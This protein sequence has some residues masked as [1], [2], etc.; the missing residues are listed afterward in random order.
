MNNK[1][2]HES[3]L[4]VEDDMINAIALISMLEGEVTKHFMPRMVSHP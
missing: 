4:L 3:V 1:L 2:H